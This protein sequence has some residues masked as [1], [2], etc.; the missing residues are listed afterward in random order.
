MSIGSWLNVQKNA[1]VGW[2]SPDEKALFD[3]FHPL[4]VQ[5]KTTALTLG[6]G[7]LQVGIQILEHAAL[8]AATAAIT[9]PPGTQV[10]AAEAAFLS[11]VAKEG[12]SAIHNAEAGAIKAAVAIIQN[13]AAPK[14]NT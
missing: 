4:M 9:A 3:F 7:D 2:F 11:I 8:G 6:K 12:I 10:P 14:A 13:T 1:V 5:V